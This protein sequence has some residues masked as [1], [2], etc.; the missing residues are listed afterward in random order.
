MIG[1]PN[2]RPQQESFSNPTKDQ[3]PKGQFPLEA[4][5]RQ[6]SGRNS[7][8][9]PVPGPKQLALPDEIKEAAKKER[10][11]NIARPGLEKSQLGKKDWGPNQERGQCQV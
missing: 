2:D 4:E 8:L 6:L 10:P 3:S 7:G 1:E 11:Q 5:S 9:V